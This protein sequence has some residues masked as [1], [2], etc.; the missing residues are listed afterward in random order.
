VANDFTKALIKS[1]GAHFDSEIASLEQVVEGFP[2][3]NVQLKYPSL[4]ID[5]KGAP[6]FTPC[7]PYI[8]VQGATDDSDPEDIFASLQWVIGQFDCEL[9]LDFWCRTKEERHVMFTNVMNV[10]SGGFPVHGLSLTLADYF[11]AIAR[12]DLVS[13]NYE[14][15]EI[16][17]Q[18]KEWRLIV[19]LTSHCH[20][21]RESVENIIETVETTVEIV[22]QSTNIEES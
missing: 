4:S 5:F 18:R 7:T 21:I 17:S 6:N 20:A 22:A 8:F 19:S 13:V 16:S 2:A 1:L 9:Q 11:D 3:A 12:F 14:D 15:S 10:M